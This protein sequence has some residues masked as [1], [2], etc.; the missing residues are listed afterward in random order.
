M[1]MRVVFAALVAIA[2]T[3]CS[4]R[5]AG[6]PALSMPPSE[7]SHVGSQKIQHVIVM[8][9]ENRSMNNI[10]AAFPGADGSTTGMLPGGKK[11]KLHRVALAEL[12]DFGH[13]Y[14]DFVGDYDGG[15]MDGFALESGSAKCQGKAGSRPYQYVNR[16]DAAPYWDIA[17]HYVLADH[18]F[19]TQ[20]SGS[21]TAHQD[22]IRGSTTIDEAKTQSLVDF[23][24]ALPWGCDAP[25]SPPTVT[26]LLV[27]NGSALK[28]EHNAGPFPCS[29]KFPGSGAYYETLRDLLDA[30]GVSWK[31]YTPRVPGLGS[32]WD[33]FDTIYPVRYGP[34]W[35]TNVTYGNTVIF[36]DIKNNSLPA[37]S[38]LIPDELNSDHPG[39]NS[40]TGPSWVA[41]IVNTIGESS[42]WDS[43]AI[44]VVWDDWGGFYDPVPP[45]FFD[46]WG[47]L[48]FRVP[49][50]LVSAYARKGTGN[51]GGYISPTRYEFGSILKFIEENWDLGS[52]G[53][54]DV[55]AKSIG[56]CFDFRQHARP[57][58]AIPSK[59]SRSYFEH[60]RP[61]LL[62]VDTE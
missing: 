34:E 33:A 53:T 14:N 41:S 62:P 57:F 36:T 52:L 60:Q 9:Q 43:T 4:G 23:P 6:A 49:M 26:S 28:N 47:G 2:M 5:Y 22:L 29:N 38:W 10:F 25:V 50:L 58:T 15:K 31:Y 3:S 59:Y 11:I 8:I 55:R 19:Q 18:M 17:Q 44:I 39:N 20:G 7:V 13:S 12:C 1:L 54:T 61:S 16:T 24:S 32:Y 21:Y 37:V 46:H 40:D 45:P 35:G 51:D 27:W 56:N 30:K 42:Y 48:G